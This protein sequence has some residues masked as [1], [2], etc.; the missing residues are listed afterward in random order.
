MS[1]VEWFNILKW[2]KPEYRV[3]GKHNEIVECSIGKGTTIWSYNSLIRCNI[4]ENTKIT[5]YVQIND[6]A[7]IGDG[8]N[9]QPY[10]LINS[11]VKI[12]NNVF[13]AGGVQFT[14]IKYPDIHPPVKKE[15]ATV[16]N[17]VVICNGAII[18]P[19]VTIGDNAVIGAGALVTK[20]IPSDEVWMGVPARYWCTREEYDCKK[21]EYDSL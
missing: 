16:G 8:C 9:L 1:D 20:S 19:G 3:L 18:F 11:N 5:S 7:E 10:V 12:G 2:D 4:G 17:N 6:G 14:D 15:P 13:I 21:K